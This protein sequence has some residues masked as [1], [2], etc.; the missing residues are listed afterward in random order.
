MYRRTKATIRIICDCKRLIIVLTMYEEMDGPKVSISDIIIS[1]VTTVTSVDRGEGGLNVFR[2]AREERCTFWVC[3]DK[4]VVRLRTRS[5]VAP[6]PGANPVAFFVRSA[7]KTSATL[8][9]MI[10]RSVERH[11]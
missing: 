10:I 11:I 1:F 8:S 2:S 4:T 3:L 7:M 5:L 9:R 6:L